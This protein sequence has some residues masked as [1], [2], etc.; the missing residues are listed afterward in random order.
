MP[1]GSLP[2]SVTGFAATIWRRRASRRRCGTSRRRLEEFRYGIFSAEHA[3]RS[4]VAFRSGIPTYP[5]T[6][7]LL[8]K[9]DTEVNAVTAAS[10]IKIKPGWDL[11]VI[12]QVREAFPGIRLMGDANSAYTL[13][14]MSTCSRKWTTMM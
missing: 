1:S 9:I 10:K 8:A 4:T 12:R 14:T 5:S 2:C 3:R 7:K 13:A 11:E 6:S